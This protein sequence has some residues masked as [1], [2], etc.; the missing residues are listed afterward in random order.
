LL[1][2]AFIATD[3]S[4]G[5]SSKFFF[6]HRNFEASFLEVGTEGLPKSHLSLGASMADWHNKT[7]DLTQ[8]IYLNLIEDSREVFSAGTTNLT[9]YRTVELLV[10]NLALLISRR[11][12]RSTEQIGILENGYHL[13]ASTR[14]GIEVMNLEPPWSTEDSYKLLNSKKISDLIDDLSVCRHFGLSNQTLVRTRFADSF[15]GLRRIQKSNSWL[16]GSYLKTQKLFARGSSKNSVFISAS[17]L[18]RFKEVLLSALLKQTP[19][20]LEIRPPTKLGSHFSARQTLLLKA[21]STKAIAFFLMKVLA[22][23]SLREGYGST[24]ERAYSLGFPKNP[25]VIFTSNSFDTDDEFKVHLAKALP[26]ASYV[27][28]QHGNNYGISKT[29]EICPELNASDIFL[30]W[31]WVGDEQRI[32]PF[33]QIKPALRVRRPNKMRGVTLFLRDELDFFFSADMHELNKRYFR[34]IEDLCASLNDLQ[35]TTH[36]RLHTSTS[37][38][39]KNFLEKAVEKMPFVAISGDR[40][41]MR[42]LLTSGMGIVFGYDSTGMLEMGTAG[43]PFFLFAPDGLGLVR[44]E[45]RANYDSLRSAGL[46]SEDPAQA[47]QLISEWITAPKKTRSMHAESLRLFTEGIAH[48][49]KNKIWKLRRILK[50]FEILRGKK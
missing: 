10:G 44:Q 11:L 4:S 45:Y 14:G 29:T 48:Y 31:G 3:T 19:S 8:S 41:S 47:A 36:L 50:G 40:P 34:N 15:L 17:Y 43:I 25:A 39:T 16:N 22:P 13:D 35:V 2:G 28:G 23:W 49:P 7:A 24:L 6:S 20:L 5:V 9:S 1:S 21:D 32:Y 12:A 27:V 38:S 46:L 42:K 18:G 37:S 33:G 30:S 26:S